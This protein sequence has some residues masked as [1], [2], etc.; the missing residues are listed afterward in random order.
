MIMEP[1]FEVMDELQLQSFSL[2]QQSALTNR[3]YTVIEGANPP[4]GYQ[5]TGALIYTLENTPSAHPLFLDDELIKVSPWLVEVDPISPLFNWLISNANDHPFVLFWSNHT[6][7]QVKPFMVNLLKARSPEGDSLFFR[8][9]DPAVFNAFIEHSQDDV[10]KNRLGGASAIATYS[11]YDSNPNRSY[12]RV[13]EL[14][15][16]EINV[17]SASAVEPPEISF[18]QQEW[19]ALCDYKRDTSLKN[20]GIYLKQNYPDHLK[21]IDSIELQ[22]FVS[23]CITQ[24]EELGF[25]T[26]NELEQWL[27][28]SLFFGECFVDN[29][30][31]S[32]IQKIVSNTELSTT[33]KLQQLNQYLDFYQ[34]RS[35]I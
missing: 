6:L 12:W 15:N 5:S 3:L 28:L 8:Y 7:E 26:Q 32:W 21:D 4:E 25:F 11:S 22:Q 35:A 10:I 33:S 2:A 19:Q 9:Y 18:N 29:H 27:D 14:K 23:R 13:R 30:N 24:G 31:Y 20:M 16:I 34:A 1:L 17:K